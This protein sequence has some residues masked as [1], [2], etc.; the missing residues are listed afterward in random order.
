MVVSDAL[1]CLPLSE[2]N[3]DE[4]A[5]SFMYRNVNYTISELILTKL[6]L[7]K[8]AERIQFCGKNFIHRVKLEYKI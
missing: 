1:S 2:R 7:R 8:H 3:V 5:S 6:A 4:R